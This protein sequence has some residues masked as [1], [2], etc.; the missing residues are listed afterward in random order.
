MVVDE[1]TRRCADRQRCRHIPR[2]RS[3][4]SASCLGDCERREVSAA[5]V[6]PQCSKLPSG[7]LQSKTPHAE[8]QSE[9]VRSPRFNGRRCSPS[10]RRKLDSQYRHWRPRSTTR[11]DL[12][13][14]TAGEG[15]HGTLKVHAHL[16][17]FSS[18]L[19]SYQPP[20]LGSVRASDSSCPLTFASAANPCEC[21]PD[22]SLG[23]ATGIAI[24]LPEE[25]ELDGHAAATAIAMP[26]AIAGVAARKFVYTA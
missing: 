15:N 25:C 10:G 11:L 14:A 12:P 2:N 7:W 19:E 22:V 1:L 4:Q 24:Q 26:C 13:L 20:F 3:W 18:P 6:S 23:S 9:S 8:P 16:S 21:R 5:S 17:P